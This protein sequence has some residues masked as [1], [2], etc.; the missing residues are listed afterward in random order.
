MADGK[1]KDEPKG[2]T[3]STLNLLN[4]LHVCN[5]DFVCISPPLTAERTSPHCLP[6]L[7]VERS[8]TTMSP[9][10]TAECTPPLT[11]CVCGRTM[12]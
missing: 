6:P 11:V 9:P 3:V 10:L 1:T 5:F 4:F 12:T 8:P 2:T 7:T